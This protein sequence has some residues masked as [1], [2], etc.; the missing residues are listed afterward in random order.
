MGYFILA[1]TEK[2]RRIAGELLLTLRLRRVP[3]DQPGQSTFR[4]LELYFTAEDFH[5]LTLVPQG[6]HSLP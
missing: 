4:D 2:L 3:R 1:P 6:Q 5:S